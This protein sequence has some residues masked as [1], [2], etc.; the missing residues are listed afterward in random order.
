M[1]KMLQF[2]PAQRIS[3]DDALRHPYLEQLHGTEPT[4]SSDKRIALGF[5]DLQLSG[6]DIR[7]RFYKEIC[8]HYAHPHA[9]APTSPASSSENQPAANGTEKAA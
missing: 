9:D 7:K 3:V 6:N 8:T 1:E 4:I 2:D 5:E